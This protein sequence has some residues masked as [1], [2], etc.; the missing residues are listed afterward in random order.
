MKYE[1]LDTNEQ[2]W[3]VDDSEHIKPK[4]KERLHSP[5]RKR[6]RTTI[7]NESPSILNIDDI[8][9]LI[10]FQKDPSISSVQ[11]MTP[12]TTIRSRQAST[13]SSINTTIVLS[14]PI[15]Y[16]TNTRIIRCSANTNDRTTEN[17]KLR[18]PM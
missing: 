5:A 16:D 7:D 15:S 3:I 11:K 17:K 4:L 8:S 14:P 18:I 12:K 13:T 1:R 6:Q 2:N 9:F 10:P